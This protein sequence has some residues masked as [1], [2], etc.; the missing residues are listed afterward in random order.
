MEKNE[1][2]KCGE[3]IRCG[4]GKFIF[5]CVYCNESFASKT[6]A[7]IHI[8]DHFEYKVEPGNFFDAKHIS[9]S[10]QKLEQ[11]I[12][13]DTSSNISQNDSQALPLKIELQESLDL[14]PLSVEQNDFIGK[15]KQESETKQS[16]KLTKKAFKSEA[17]KQNKSFSNKLAWGPTTYQT[18]AECDICGKKLQKRNLIRHMNAHANLKEFIC[19]VCH[20]GFNNKNYLD[21]HVVI[22]SDVKKFSCHICGS[23]FHDQRDLNKHV[24]VHTGEKP[25]KCKICDKRFPYAYKLTVHLR[26]HTGEKPYKCEVC[27]KSFSTV[28]IYST[29]KRLHTMKKTFQCDVCGQAF[30]QAITMREH[31]RRHTGERP[32]SCHICGKA[33]AHKNACR[34][35]TYLHTGEKPYKCRFCD[36]AFSQNAARR[37]HERSV[38]NDA[39]RII[40]VGN[41]DG[42][43]E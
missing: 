19:N 30:A 40:T 26:M 12:N 20:K 37:S 38:H 21:R 8:E 3:I 4:P 24:R 17:T 23:Q 36:L 41:V 16:T 31:R 5:S 9:Q 14:D 18:K 27:N 7:L 39:K 34:Q 35:H 11:N 6:N 1:N 2:I 42:K 15:I 29:H 25:F 33:F 32:Y 28:S 13:E 10:V 43:I 22:H